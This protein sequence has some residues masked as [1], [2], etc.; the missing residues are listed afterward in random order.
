MLAVLVVIVALV[1][2]IAAVE[3]FMR[4]IDWIQR[5]F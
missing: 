1:V 3:V 2:S 5:T 4:I